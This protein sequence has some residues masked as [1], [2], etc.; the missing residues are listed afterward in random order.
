MSSMKTTYSIL[1]L[2]YRG[3]LA[4]GLLSG[5][6]DIRPTGKSLLVLSSAFATIHPNSFCCRPRGIKSREVH[7][8]P[9]CLRL[10]NAKQLRGLLF[11]FFIR[12]QQSLFF[13]IFVI[14]KTNTSH[15]ERFDSHCHR[16]PPSSRRR[17]GR[18]PTIIGRQCRPWSLQAANFLQKLA[19]GLW[20]LP[21]FGNHEFR[22]LWLGWFLGLQDGLLPHRPYHLQDSWTNHPHL[23]ISGISL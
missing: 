23:E 11:V 13:G 21:Y 6:H 7:R 19:P 5:P 8:R 10:G 16:Q 22:Q 2:V 15:H 14:S 3:R 18:P 17:H 9:L 1:S 4:L 20:N 12:R